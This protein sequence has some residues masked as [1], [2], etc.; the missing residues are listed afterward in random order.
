[1]NIL[2]KFIYKS[3]EN[4]GFGRLRRTKVLKITSFVFALGSHTTSEYYDIMSILAAKQLET[5]IFM[6]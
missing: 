6:V 2:V 1:M 5:F 3:S 4:K